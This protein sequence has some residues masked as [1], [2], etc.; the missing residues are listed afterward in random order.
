MILCP[1]PKLRQV[2]INYKLAI[3]AS[4]VLASVM[5]NA[6]D[7]NP[8]GFIRFNGVWKEHFDV[9]QSTLGIDMSDSISGKQR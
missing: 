1:R 9:S 6:T 5:A 3:I 4:L 8:Y 2:L 7:I